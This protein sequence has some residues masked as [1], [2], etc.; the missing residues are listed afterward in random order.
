MLGR[1]VWEGMCSWPDLTN[2]TVTLVELID[3]HRSLNLREHIKEQA[4]IIQKGEEKS[5]D[6]YGD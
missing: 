4:R 5:T 1:P 6:G 2:G 3:M